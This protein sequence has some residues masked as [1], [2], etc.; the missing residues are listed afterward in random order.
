MHHRRRR[1]EAHTVAALAGGQAEG[2]CEVSFSRATVAQQQHVLPTQQKLTTRQLQ[3]HG[4]VQ[5]WDG[6]ELEGVQALDHWKAGL[7]D[8]AFGGPPLAIQ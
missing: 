3:H 5:R 2:E 7:M 4:L 6:Q 8:A 1:R